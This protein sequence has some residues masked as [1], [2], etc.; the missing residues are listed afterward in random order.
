MQDNSTPL[1]VTL[2]DVY[3]QVSAL[4]EHLGK[5]EA[6][7]DLAEA[8]T[9]QEVKT[10]GIKL[11]DHEDRIRFVERWTYAITLGVPILAWFV[12]NYVPAA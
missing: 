8:L 12:A 3:V 5:V 4:S 11:T 9:A 6:K 2:A 7:I 1:V 10:N